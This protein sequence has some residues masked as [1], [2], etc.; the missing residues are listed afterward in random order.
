MSACSLGGAVRLL[1][2]RSTVTSETDFS[3]SHFPIPAEPETKLKDTFG[4]QRWR[5][6]M[7]AVG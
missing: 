5:H 1:S 2:I 3:M 6:G 4:R 7:E